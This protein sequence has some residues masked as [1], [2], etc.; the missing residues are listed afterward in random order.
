MYRLRLR[1]GWTLLPIPKF[2]AF[3]SNL[4]SFL[5]A[6]AEV[7]FLRGAGAIFLDLIA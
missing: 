2:F 1:L 4:G 3:L 6:T 7:A 5:A